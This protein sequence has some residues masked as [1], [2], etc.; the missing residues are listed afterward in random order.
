MTGM[1][2]EGMD[3]VLAGRLQRLAQARGWSEAQALQH[4]IERGLLALEAEGAATLESAE[5]E[6]LKEAIAAL[7]QI[8]NS[9]FAAIGKPPPGE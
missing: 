9:A 5:A 6:V 1:T 7:E 3:P 8:P 2:L 4:A